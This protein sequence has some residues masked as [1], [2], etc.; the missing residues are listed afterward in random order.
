MSSSISSMESDMEDFGESTSGGME[1]AAKQTQKAADKMEKAYESVEEIKNRVRS[2]YQSLNI[3]DDDSYN[4][5]AD[6]DKE[7]ENSEER[8][9]DLS[10]ILDALLKRKKQLEGFL[11]DDGIDVRKYNTAISNNNTE[12]ISSSI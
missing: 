8:V 9:K 12:S 11:S 10:N 1:R 6:W 7:I 3:Y 2:S 5:N 4:M